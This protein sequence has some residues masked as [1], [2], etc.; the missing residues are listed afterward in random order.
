MREEEIRERTA[1]LLDAYRELTGDTCVPGIPDFLELRKAALE[2]L[3]LP[4]VAEKSPEIV[5]K[6][7]AARSERPR[8]AARQPER[9]KVSAEIKAR[10]DETP[11]AKVVNMP[12]REEEFPDEVPRSDFD[13][14]R[15]IVDPW[16]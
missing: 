3:G 10:Q 11:A 6:A 9:K 15:S 8:T 2:E 13:I 4:A 1:L 7:P 5:R 12:A 16:N 14:L